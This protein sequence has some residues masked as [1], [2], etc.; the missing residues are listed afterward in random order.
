MMITIGKITT[1]DVVLDKVG[2]TSFDD[3]VVVS[4]IPLHDVLVMPG[5]RPHLVGYI[6]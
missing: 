4:L 6:L 1:D 3:W 2:M 5:R